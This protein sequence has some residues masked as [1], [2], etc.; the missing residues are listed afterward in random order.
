MQELDL[1]GL[2]IERLSSLATVENKEPV[3][4]E[5]YLLEQLNIDVKQISEEKKKLFNKN[6]GS[7]S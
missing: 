1:N 4:V 7:I 5:D 2:T 3:A 6:T